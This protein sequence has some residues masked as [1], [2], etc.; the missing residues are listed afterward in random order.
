MFTWIRTLPIWARIVGS[1]ILV[2]VLVNGGMIFWGLRQ[3]RRMALE[4]ADAFAAASTHMAFT[5]LG[6]AMAS[7][8]P[9]EIMAVVGELQK[10]QGI[11][12]LRVVP[13]DTVKQQMKIGDAPQADALEQ[14]ILQEGKPHFGV[15]ERGGSPVYRAIMPIA[16]SRNFIGRDCTTC[17]QVA[18]GT[19]LGVVSLE[20]GLEKVQQAS[21]DFRFFMI[22]LGS[23][24]GIIFLLGFYYLCRRII[25]LPLD[26]V[27][28]Q[29]KDMSQGEGD[30][31]NRLIVRSQDEIGELAKW[32]NLFVEK[33][34]NTVRVI[35][36]N[37]QSLAGSAEQL[38]A[39]SQ[40]MSS[41]SE[42]TAT[43]AN[44]V[45]AASE[46]VSKNVQTVAAGAEEMSASIKEIA[47]NTSDA[48]RVAQEAV[49]V[50]EKT[51]QTISKL[52]E[53]STEIGNVIKVITSIAEQTNLLAL[54]ATI[55]AARAGEAGKGFAVV[56]NEVKELAKQ[57]GQATENISLKISTIQHDTREAVETIQQ[58]GG[59]INQINDIANTIASAVEEQSVTT[60]EMARNVEEAAKGSNEIVQNITGVAQAAQSTASGATQ[61]QAAA[62]ELARLAAELQNVIGHFKY[63]AERQKSEPVGNMKKKTPK[64]PGMKPQPIYQ[65]EN[66]TLHML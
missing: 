57:T 32:F 34:Q 28:S 38:T 65:T 31:T 48:A 35:G 44:V 29:L 30:L 26:A 40:Q 19:V 4:Q 24:F 66:S 41:N 39:V 47:K 37:I 53:S 64:T 6:V 2:M 51:N 27:V 1:F 14:H 55:E 50:A 58:I 10:S 43:Q 13:T 16:A 63:D 5:S 22:L 45:S 11:K 3:Q 25:V 18:E 49:E 23:G 46:Q 42:E 8:D 54:N 15:E 21:A 9:K 12:A 62:Q 33:I 60:N 20:I 7:G 17:H 52:G 61:T 36:N 59:I 56:A